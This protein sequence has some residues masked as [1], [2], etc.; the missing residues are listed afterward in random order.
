MSAMGRNSAGILRI[1]SFACGMILPSLHFFPLLFDL[2][3]TAANLSPFDVSIFGIETVRFR[4][5]GRLLGDPEWLRLG[6]GAVLVLSGWLIARFLP[7]FGA[8][9]DKAWTGLRSVPERSF[10]F[11][12]A[13]AQFVL[14]ASISIFVFDR[15]PHVQDEIGQ[16]FQARIFA[17]GELY[18]R[19]PADPELFSFY[20]VILSDKWYSQHPPGLPLLLAPFLLLGI[21]WLLNPTLGAGCTL[22]TYLLG[23]TLWGGGAGRGA[24]LLLLL[25]PFHA[26]MGASFMNHT[27][28][29]FLLL[30]FAVLA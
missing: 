12:L 8:I 1:V 19:P 28:T 7:G 14:L 2:P 23:R 27:A 5:V 20:S 29:L 17:S 18:A 26:F 11:G 6:G 24:A 4:T 3:A 25:S 30:L 22:L 10:V 15:I 9:L 16:Y 13:L 21:P